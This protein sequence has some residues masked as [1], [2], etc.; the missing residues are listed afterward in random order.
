MTSLGNE[1]GGPSRAEAMIQG[2]G[3]SMI[4]K[5][6]KVQFKRPVTFPDTVRVQSLASY[7]VSD[8]PHS[9]SY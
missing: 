2:R 9:D 5:S 1:L 4:L 7:S 6:I 3:L 8:A